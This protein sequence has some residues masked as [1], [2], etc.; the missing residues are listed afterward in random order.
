MSA[1]AIAA[2]LIHVVTFAS[3]ARYFGAFPPVTCRGVPRL[4]R[5]QCAVRRRSHP[6][7][8]PEG[9]VL[10]GVLGVPPGSAAEGGIAAHGEEARG[11]RR[12]DR[13]DGRA[14]GHPA[15]AGPHLC[16]P[17]PRD[18]RRAVA[19][20]DERL[21]PHDPRLGHRERGSAGGARGERGQ[22]ERG[23]QDRRG[24]LPRHRGKEERGEEG[25]Q[26]PGIR[27]PFR[28]ALV[29]P[30]RD[31]GRQLPAHREHGSRGGAA[32]GRAGRGGDA[33]HHPQV[34]RGRADLR[35]PLARSC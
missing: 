7:R 5:L 23:R 30:A 32:P 8:E 34:Q 19:H 18:H 20:P 24:G 33:R 6:G 27:L 13:P 4:C 29:L 2:V 17:H 1:A 25:G 12:G 21:Q 3:N 11:E 22:G 14:A 28:H 15:Q 9:P 10:P 31:K 26:G 16:P 35:V